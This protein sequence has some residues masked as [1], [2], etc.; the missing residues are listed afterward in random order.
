MYTVLTNG[1]FP[2]LL[3]IMEGE[4]FRKRKNAPCKLFPRNRKN[5]LL[6]LLGSFRIAIPS[7]KEFR[8]IVRKYAMKPK[9]PKPLIL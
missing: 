5:K 8:F 4:I 3:Q 1:L 6:Q 2:F 7:F 9:T